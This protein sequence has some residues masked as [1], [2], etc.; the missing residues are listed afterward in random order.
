MDIEDVK[1]WI[2]ANRKGLIVGAAVALILRS[3]I[4]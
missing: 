4:R 1:D 2:Y 3:I